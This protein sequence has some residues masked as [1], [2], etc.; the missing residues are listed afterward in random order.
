VLYR[1][2]AYWQMFLL[3]SSCEVEHACAVVLT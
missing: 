3:M 2:T 1:L